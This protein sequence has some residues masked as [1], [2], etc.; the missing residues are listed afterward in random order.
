MKEEL[1]YAGTVSGV[2]SVMTSGMHLMVKLHADSLDSMPQLEVSTMTV[3][4]GA[5]ND[6]IVR[7]L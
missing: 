5:S 6:A 3:C 7:T 2:P 4:N 1:K